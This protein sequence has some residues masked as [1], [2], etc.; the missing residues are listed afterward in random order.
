MK[1]GIAS[2]A[3]IL[4]GFAVPVEAHQKPVSKA[5][6]ANKKIVPVPDFSV[7]TAFKDALLELKGAAARAAPCYNS[8]VFPVRI[9]PGKNYA[10]AQDS[11][12]CV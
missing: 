12:G 9:N 7:L 11:Q 5:T 2:L 6:T 8:R 1:N 3:I 10:E 4:S